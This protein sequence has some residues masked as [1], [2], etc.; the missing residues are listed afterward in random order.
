M[1]SDE[2]VW[3]LVSYVVLIIYVMLL[4]TEELFSGNHL[5]MLEK[6]LGM[7]VWLPKGDSLM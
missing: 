3:T 7:T 6:L 1:W 2:S 4:Y 5:T